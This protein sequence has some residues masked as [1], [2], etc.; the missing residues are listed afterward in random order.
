MVKRFWKTPGCTWIWTQQRCWSTDT[1]QWLWDGSGLALEI[2]KAICLAQQ[3]FTCHDNSW[4]RRGGPGHLSIRHVRKPQHNTQRL[5]TAVIGYSAGGTRSS[6]FRLK[7]I[8]IKWRKHTHTGSV[9]D[10]W[11]ARHRNES[12]DFC[13]ECLSFLTL[14]K[15]SH[16]VGNVSTCRL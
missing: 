10:K 11:D 15:A 12:S 6:S 1:A 7:R 3:Q 14:W 16:Y 5:T 2:N 13:P 4:G 8:N 9:W